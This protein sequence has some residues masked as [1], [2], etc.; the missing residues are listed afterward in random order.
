MEVILSSNC[1]SFT[2]SLGRGFGYY[3]KSHLSYRSGKE[4]FFS[5]R[6]SKGP[7]PPDGHLRFIFACAELAIAKLHI[8]DIRVSAEE[9]RAAFNEAHVLYGDRL[10]KADAE[11]IINAREVLDFKKWV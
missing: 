11:Q 7:I 3:I 5:Q 6:N 1:N 10:V 2:G 4:R 8:V 9:M